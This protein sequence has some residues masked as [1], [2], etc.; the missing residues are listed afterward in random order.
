MAASVNRFAP[1]VRGEGKGIIVPMANWV[2]N[3]VLVANVAQT[4]TL[5]TGTNPAGGGT[6]AINPP[7]G[8]TVTATILRVTTN[9]ALVYVNAQTAAAVPAANN[10]LGNGS[11][12][13]PGGSF[14]FQVPVGVASISF[15]ASGAAVISIEAWW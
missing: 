9:G 3:L 15:I 2:D 14:M 7:P 13:I 5:P 6:Q 8:T 12:P 4:Y 10:I 1:V 11:V